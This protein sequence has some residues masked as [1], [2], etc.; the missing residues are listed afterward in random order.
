MSIKTSKTVSFKGGSVKFNVVYNKKNMYS[1][2]FLEFET[3]QSKLL[4]RLL[5]QFCVEKCLTTGINV[6]NGIISAIH[7]ESSIV[8]YC[9][10]NKI[11]NNI[12]NIYMYLSKAKLNSPNQKI[13]KTGDYNKL[14]K[15]IKNFSVRV[16]G[17]CKTF[18][19]NLDED[20][21]KI[22]R[23]KDCM[24][25]V[26]AKSRDNISVDTEPKDDLT[27]D[28]YFQKSNDSLG[29]LYLSIIARDVP[30]KIT[31]GKIQFYTSGGISKFKDMLLH[32]NVYQGLV[33]SFLTQAGNV[34]SPASN[35]TGGKKYKEKINTIMD[36]E[37]QM[38]Y[39]YSHL[40]GFSYQFKGVDEI[41][42][43]DPTLMSGL[44]TLK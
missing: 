30:C 1:C 5:E 21:A 2:V 33:K 37:N 26:E 39:I 36:V 32:K 40:R 12:I 29:Q 23:F 31:K 38:S 28:Y 27:M 15:E 17:K 10:E 34:G 4:E 11:T 43:V 7:G 42:K 44:K 25:R 18:I 22:Q 8:I 16:C 24:E 6:N 14:S 13:V 3:S 20:S 41:K 9:P 35:D 19:K